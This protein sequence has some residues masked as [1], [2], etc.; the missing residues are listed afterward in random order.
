MNNI[1]NAFSKNDFLIDNGQ[2]YQITQK[3]DTH[4]FYKLFFPIESEKSIACSIPVDRIPNTNKRKPITKEL[5]KKLL[6]SLSTPVADDDVFDYSQADEIYKLNDIFKTAQFI[7]SIYAE[8]HSTDTGLSDSKKTVYKQGMQILSH[9]LAV[10][11]GI[12]PSESS[13][14]IFSSLRK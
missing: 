6:E 5:A 2:V 10:V 12:T 9:E 13:K 1:T 3:N 4:I 11:M 8:K 7:K 14:L